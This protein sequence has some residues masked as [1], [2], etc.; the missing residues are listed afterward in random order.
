L[1]DAGQAPC[2]ERQP[3]AGKSAGFNGENAETRGA[4]IKTA[5][6]RHEPEFAPGLSLRAIA[7][8]SSV[9]ASVHLDKA[10]HLSGDSLEF[11]A[12]FILQSKRTLVHLAQAVQEYGDVDFLIVVLVFQRFEP[13]MEKRVFYAIDQIRDNAF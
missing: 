3:L 2:S 11:A 6:R 4:A 1:I 7:L 5:P 12:I 13:A 8:A 10:P 9:V